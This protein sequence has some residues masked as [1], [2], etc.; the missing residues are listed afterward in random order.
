MNFLDR[1]SG[2][3]VTPSANPGNLPVTGLR[4]Y[5]A[6]DAVPRDPANF[7]LSG[8]NDGLSG[9]WK[10]IASGQLALPDERNAGGDAVVIPPTGNLDA[11]HQ[12]VLFDNELS[13]AHY[14]VTFPLV[15][16]EGAAN[17]M[18]IAEVEFLVVPEP[19]AATLAYLAILG[20]AAV[21]RRRR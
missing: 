17:S 16:D 13:F 12:T 2:F 4:F 8:S 14:R 5:T 9:P 10:P 20:L 19:A 6:N 1:D 21:G 3:A 7:V 11:V 15:K 18:Q